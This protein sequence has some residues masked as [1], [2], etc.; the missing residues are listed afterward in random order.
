MPTITNRFTKFSVAALLG[1]VA[2][3]VSP[4][5]A[6]A[7]ETHGTTASAVQPQAGYACGYDGYT[8]FPQPLYNHCGTGR[9]QIKVSHFF[10]QYTYFC[11]APGTQQIPQGSSQWRIIDAVSDGK[12]C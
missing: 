10:W 3:L 4:A 5:A 2:A 1:V 9:V 12:F 6:S 7:A 8:G 11:A